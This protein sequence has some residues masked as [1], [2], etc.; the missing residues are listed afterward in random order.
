MDRAGGPFR[1]L[2][3]LTGLNS[4]Y[5]SARLRPP[6]CRMQNSRG[7][8]KKSVMTFAKLHRSTFCPRLKKGPQTGIASKSVLN[9]H[10]RRYSRYSVFSLEVSQLRPTKT[11]MS[12]PQSRRITNQITCKASPAKTNRN[13]PSVCQ[14]IAIASLE[15]ASIQQTG[16]WSR[17]MLKIQQTEHS[18]FR[19]IVHQE[20]IT[21]L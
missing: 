20:V 3:I 19:F 2:T 21:L 12:Q 15:K 10:L 5:D 16:G 14:L 7:W 13:I 9:D 8:A 6:A 18:P 17:P 4:E 1:V 11:R